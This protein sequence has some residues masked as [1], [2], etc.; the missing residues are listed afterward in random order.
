M[1][2]PSSR[3][4]ALR[5]VLKW[6]VGASA[7][8]RAGQ[9]APGLQSRKARRRA[10]VPT[11]TCT[12][13]RASACG[14]TA[15][16]TSAFAVP[17]NA[18]RRAPARAALRRRRVPSRS[19]REQCRSRQPR[20]RPPALR[21]RGHGRRQ[22]NKPNVVCVRCENRLSAT[23]VPMGELRNARRERAVRQGQ[24][25]DVPFDFFPYAGIQRDVCLYTT[26][27]A[28]YVDGVRVTTAVHAPT[29][30]RQSRSQGAS[31]AAA[32][33]IVVG[34]ARRARRTTPR[35]TADVFPCPSP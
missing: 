31:A 26:P 6:H 7:R 24:Y 34:G 27:K 3:R 32:N 30:A 17:K 14:R 10:G 4:R 20:G 23:T 8:A 13:K 11:T 29:A 16:G 12:P 15:C 2:Y 21:V 22:W 1:L 18:A 35:T 25:P 28:A 33:L 5:R 19:L 9:P